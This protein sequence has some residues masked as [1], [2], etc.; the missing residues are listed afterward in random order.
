MRTVTAKFSALSKV[1]VI[2]SVA[3]L[4]A[5]AGPKYAFQQE[6]FDAKQGP[7]DHHFNASKAVVYESLKRVALRQG[8]AVEHKS[9]SDYTLVVSKQYQNGERNTLLTISGL[10]T[11]G[12]AG[13][14][15]WIAAQEVTLKSHESTQTASVGLLLGVSIPVP[16]GTVATLTK[17]RGETVMDKQFYSKIYAAIEK[18]IPD[19]QAQIEV[20]NTEDD[21]RLRA[22]IEKKLRI[23]MEIRAKL[24][25]EAAA[26]KEQQTSATTQ[27][28]SVGTA[29]PAL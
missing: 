5:C 9:A 24:E 21:T 7:F 15:A 20:T 25:K 17:E 1:L 29:S 10:V 8:F 11:G 16:T 13:A 23:E 27:A 14:D 18:E 19:V 26:A 12:N 2:A 4:S 3:F 6:S 28:V 22:E